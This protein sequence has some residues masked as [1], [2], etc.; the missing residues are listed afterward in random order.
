MPDLIGPQ[1]LFRE[2]REKFHADLLESVLTVNAQ[3]VSTNADKDIQ[4]MS[5]Y[6]VIAADCL[7]GLRELPDNSVDSV[8]TDPPYG[9]SFMGKAWDKGV[10]SVEIWREVYRV[11][12]PGGH[13][14]SFAGTRTQHRMASAIEDA[15]FEIRDMLAWTYGSGMPKGLNVGKAMEAERITGSSSPTAQRRA[16]MG[17]DYEM[18]PHAG[19]PGYGRVGNFHDKNTGNAGFGELSAEASAWEGW[20]TVLK[21]A[22]EPITLARKPLTGPVVANVREWGTGALNIDGCRVPGEDEVSTHSRRADSDIYSAMGPVETGQTRGQEMGRYPANLL[23]D[24]SDEVLSVFPRSKSAKPSKRQE[25]GGEFPADN[26]IGLGLAEI[27]R[28]GFSDSGSAA[29]FFYCAKATKADREDGLDGFGE[30]TLNRVNSGGLEN[31][32]RWAP[33]A[34]KNTHPTVKPTSLMRWMCRLITPP[35]GIVLDPFCG[36]GSTGR[37]AVLEGFRFIGY[38][39]DEEHAKVA[40]ARI[41]AAVKRRDEG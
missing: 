24:G 12:K 34:R 36:S 23:H 27:R 21:P 30:G 6:E 40:R 29:R 26:T 28:T 8:V 35:G 18:S 14:L 41:E 7:E 20:N 11:L 1:A 33:V 2:A 19:E 9:I 25:R 38:E 4:A 16:A 32:P 37:G 31:D 39:I 13:L 10:P 5:D 22:L 3:G 17:D 15:G